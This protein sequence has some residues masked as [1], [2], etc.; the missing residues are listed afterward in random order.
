MIKSLQ[1][2][3]F[4]AILGIFLSHLLF[5]QNTVYKNVFNRYFYGGYCGVTFFIVLSGFV[6]AYN[7][8]DKF[9][10]VHK[11]VSLNF[12][13][14]RLMKIYPIHILTFVIALPLAYKII[15]HSPLKQ[16]VNM[17]LNILL[18]QSFVPMQGV[19]FS[20]NSVSWYLS[21]CILFYALTPF[22]IMLIHKI[23]KTST[24]L[25][26]YGILIYMF[27]FTIVFLGRDNSNAHWLFYINPFFR[28]F[29][30]ILG[31]LCG[32]YVKSIVVKN[33]NSI[34]FYTILEVLSLLAFGVAYYMYPFIQQTFTYGVY[35]LPFMVFITIIFGI[36]KGYISKILS[37]KFLVYLGGISFEFYMIHHLVIDYITH[38]T[39]NEHPIIVSISCFAISIISAIGLS[40]LFKSKHAKIKNNNI[41]AT[42]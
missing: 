30:Y 9:N 2:L 23:A 10:E 17:I 20:F 13:K 14:K 38:F 11:D 39:V 25:I 24:H 35:Y 22:L 27:T 8:Y 32:V 6:M 31:L 26:V 33:K 18:L 15:M 7:Y 28:I 37:N 4:I 16:I 29:D 3:R 40:K 5:L 41:E 42:I 36:Q 1:S 21:A 34:N 12:F 19:N